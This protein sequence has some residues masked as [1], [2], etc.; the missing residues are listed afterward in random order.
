MKRLFTVLLCAIL[1][2]S[3]LL[4]TLSFAQSVSELI[5]EYGHEIDPDY[6]P[7]GGSI[8]VD[9]ST[10]AI[11]WSEN[12]RVD[13]PPAS[14]TK[15]MVVYLAYQAMERGEFTEDTEVTVTED[16]AYLSTDTEL[17]NNYMPLGSVF[18][19]S[20]LI[21]LTLIPSSASAVLLLANQL[22]P[23][24][25]VVY[26]MNQTAREMGMVKTTYVN[27]VGAHNDS[28]IPYMDGLKPGEDNQSNAFDQ[29][30]FATHLVREYPEVLAHTINQS[31]LLKPGTEFEEWFESRNLS[32]PGADY[33]YDGMDG[34][35]TGSTDEAAFNIALTAKQG[36][37]RLVAIVLGTGVWD[38]WESEAY[39]S[40]IGNVLMDY[41]FTN[42]S[43]QSILSAG[44]HEIDGQTI[45][46][47]EDL[48]DIASSAQAPSFV[49]AGERLMQNTDRTY[50]PGF[51]AP[52][53]A[54][55]VVSPPEE[56]AEEEEVI[57]VEEG[58]E[59]TDPV[60]QKNIRQSLFTLTLYLI[61]LLLLLLILRTSILRA[62]RK[63]INRDKRKWRR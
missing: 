15:M 40:I 61:G 59:P 56:E 33:A 36:D 5:T 22:G 21:D 23:H 55:E 26:L 46:T 4:Q 51:E 19:I 29:A 10:G 47:Q 60:L 39:R 24:E 20:E 31:F 54:F 62:I 49:M 11:L 25:K 57:A 52:S 18:T 17:S 13:W 1:V 2:I 44:E 27:V 53:V 7:K 50:L 9:A 12:D 6:L 37:T 48:Y 3:P 58:A 32:L 41:T 63:R 45:V 38:N 14:L 42:F 30:I 28:L 35:K 8:V 34:L 16:V 43:T